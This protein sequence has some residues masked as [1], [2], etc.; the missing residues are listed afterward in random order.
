MQVSVYRDCIVC[1][2]SFITCIDSIKCYD[3]RKKPKLDVSKLV[4][5]RT[6]FKVKKKKNK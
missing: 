2:R 6:F 4:D 1:K 5:I 3:C